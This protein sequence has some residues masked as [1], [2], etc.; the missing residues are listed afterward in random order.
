MIASN[1]GYLICRKNSG[2]FISILLF[3]VA[4]Y[5]LQQLVVASEESIFLK[6]SHD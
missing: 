6:A 4:E 5:H 2:S 3:S 1:Q